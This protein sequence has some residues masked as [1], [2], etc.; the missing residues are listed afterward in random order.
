MVV[1][2][3]VIKETPESSPGEDTSLQPRRGLSSELDH[4]GTLT[5]DFQP[6]EL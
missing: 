4:A 2:T 6:P 5:L 3:A 1:I